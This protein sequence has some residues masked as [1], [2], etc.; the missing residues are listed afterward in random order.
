MTASHKLLPRFPHALSK[1]D[2]LR[3]LKTEEQ[4]LTS[5][6]AE[7]RL[8]VHGENRLPLIA[9]QS[10]IRLVLKQFRSWLVAL[11]IVAV[12]I[13]WFAGEHIDAWVITFVILINA[14]IGVFH[15]Y[16]ANKAMDALRKMVV[17]DAKVIRDGKMQTTSTDQIVPGDIIYLEEGDL[18]PAD[19]RLIGVSNFRCNESALTGESIPVSKLTGAVEAAAYVADR[20]NMV[21]KGT[22]AVSGNALAGVCATGIHTQLG[23][24]SRSLRQI[25]DVRSDF[26]RKTDTLAR[27]MSFIAIGS[28]VALFLM[29]YFIQDLPLREMLLVSIAALVAAIPEGLPAV[30]AIVLAI[31]ARRMANRNAIIRDFTATETLGAVTGN[32]N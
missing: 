18:I 10:F 6:E 27:Q 19:A 17:D 15:E 2:A 4:G 5:L 7:T 11:L 32:S 20:K 26:L 23:H 3:E 21:W 12:V 24:I 28:T 8:K 22:F 31:G 13:S 1:E 29:G 16:R 25:K 9:R 14:G 30:L